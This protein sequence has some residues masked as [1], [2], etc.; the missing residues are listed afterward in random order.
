M[1]TGE[2]MGDAVQRAFER[3][4]REYLDEMP[5]RIAELTALAHAGDDAGV[6][7]RLHQLAG[8][9]GSHG[10]P[11]ISVVAREMDAALAAAG[12]AA[13]RAAAVEFGLGRLA[14]AVDVGRES[15]R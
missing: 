7:M 12:N 15:L 2:P 11:E 5:A 14:A 9:G 10:F 4:R 1:I 3:L 8:S 6:R 13:D